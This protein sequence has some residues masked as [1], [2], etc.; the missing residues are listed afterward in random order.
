MGWDDE[1]TLI[2]A[3]QASITEE[4]I[5]RLRQGPLSYPTDFPRRLAIL[6]KTQ[7]ETICHQ[8]ALFLLGLTNYA[9]L[10]SR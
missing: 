2:L 5:Q 9:T 3:E 4:I 6:E 1:K 7:G 8:T 10:Q